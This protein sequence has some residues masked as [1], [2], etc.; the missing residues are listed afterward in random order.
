MMPHN[1]AAGASLEAMLNELEQLLRVML[2]DHRRLLSC[3]GAKREGI[4]TAN[5]DR[6]TKIC[7]EENTIVQQVAK[8]ERRRLE[9]IGQITHVFEPRAAQPLSMS[10]IAERAAEPQRARLQAL[11]AQLRD[12]VNDLRQQSSIVRTAAEALGRHMSGIVQTVHSALSRARV[13][14]QRGTVNL[15]LQLQSVVDIK[16]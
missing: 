7:G 13:Y 4:R 12:A 14:G 9:L 16:S 6:I 2:E 11:A 5:I 1:S 15:G 8:A 10:D 3:I